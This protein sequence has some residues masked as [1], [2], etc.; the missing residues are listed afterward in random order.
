[1]KLNL[2]D[3]F[4]GIGGFSLGLERTGRFKTIAF[5]EIDSYASKVLSKWWPHVPN[6]SHGIVGLNSLLKRARTPSRL[7]FRVRI[8]HS[9]AQAPDLPGLA[10]DLYG[11]SCEP[12]AWFDQQSRTWRTWQRCLVEDWEI[13]SG[14][15]PR[16]GMTRNGIAYRRAPLVPLTKGIESGS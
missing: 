5:C 10:R 9:L 2:L 13:F 12:F 15:W 1:M 3:L 6:F 8:S 7:D 11:H 4:S 16:S 14:T